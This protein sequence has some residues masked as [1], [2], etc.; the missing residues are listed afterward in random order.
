MHSQSYPKLSFKLEHSGVVPLGSFTKALERINSR[1]GRFVKSTS[2]E[3]EGNLYIS[4]I[5]EGSIIVDLVGVGAAA[6]APML[7][8]GLETTNSLWDFGRNIG[9]LLNYFRG[10]GPRPEGLSISDCDDVKAIVGPAAHTDGGGLSISANTIHIGT[11]I[12]LDRSEALAIENRASAER[13]GLAATDEQ[14]WREVLLVWHQVRDAPAVRD[15]KSSPDKGIIAAIGPRALPVT[16]ADPAA[17]ERM[18]HG[19]TNPFLVGFVV[20]VKVLTTPSGPS[21]YRILKLHDVQ[22]LDVG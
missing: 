19:S 11:L 6:T 15:G 17:K 16:F 5:R 14:T 18:T 8:Q 1:Y 9:G 22:P 7:L 3:E 12:Q 13:A 10:K 2:P 21:G 20:D 4:E